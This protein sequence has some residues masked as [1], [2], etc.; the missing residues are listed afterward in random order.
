VADPV[1]PVITNLV[2]VEQQL[3]LIATPQGTLQDGKLTKGSAAALPALTAAAGLLTVLYKVVGDD[4]KN[5]GTRTAAALGD[6]VNA[7]RQVADQL[8]KVTSTGT[9]VQKTLAALQNALAVAQTIL[10]GTSPDLAAGGQFFGQLNSVLAGV[11]GDIGKAV[12]VLYQF[13]QELAAIQDAIKPH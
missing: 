11:G 7:L 4:L 3:A 5:A 12:T 9:D 6:A 1:A 10:P 2:T 8:Q 13:A